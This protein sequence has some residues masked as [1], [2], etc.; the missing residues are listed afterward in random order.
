MKLPHGDTV[1]TSVD[2]SEGEAP[3][4]P[5]EITWESGSDAIPWLE[6]SPGELVVVDKIET[7]EANTILGIINC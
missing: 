2:T 4:E 6:T 3:P 5:A 1:D 7:E